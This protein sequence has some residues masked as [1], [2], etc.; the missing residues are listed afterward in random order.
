M[1]GGPRVRKPLPGGGKPPAPAQPPA[2]PAPPKTAAPAPKPPVASTT[3]AKP[4]EQRRGSPA[5]GNTGYH[6]ASLI[7]LT[8][9][10][11]RGSGAQLC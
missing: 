7:L 2:K 4:K 1:Q 5:A 9:A 3:A 11:P 8:D 10:E 6:A